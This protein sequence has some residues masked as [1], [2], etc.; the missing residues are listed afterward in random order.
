[1]LAPTAPSLNAQRKNTPL[2][3]CICAINFNSIAVKFGFVKG[4]DVFANR[5]ALLRYTALY[6][7]WANTVRPYDL[8]TANCLTVGEHSVLPRHAVFYASR[9][10]TVRPY[11]RVCA[12]GKLPNLCLTAWNNIRP[13]PICVDYPKY[14]CISRRNPHHP[15]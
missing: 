8:P 7:P 5:Y 10:N 6:G 14:N 2:F 4:Y 12:D 9:A 11:G 1:M 15:E 13:L 3:H